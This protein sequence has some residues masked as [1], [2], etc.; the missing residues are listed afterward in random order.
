MKQITI[1]SEDQGGLVTRIIESL[2][3]K[4]I[5]IRTINCQS[6]QDGALLTLVVDQYDYA[7][8]VLTEAG[9]NAISDDCVLIHVQ[10]KL[11]ALAGIARQIS[12][13]DI[14]IRSL[15]LIMQKA[16]TWVV[17]VSTDNDARVREIFAETA[18]N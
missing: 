15:N 12:D 13:Q 17:A 18:V 9:Y 16:D 8:K 6:I 14:R 5:D 10:D 1:I 11:G 2:S 4:G 7:L 3:A